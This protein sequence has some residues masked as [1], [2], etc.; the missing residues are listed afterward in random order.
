MSDRFIA[1]ANNIEVAAEIL[2]EDVDV[3]QVKIALRMTVVDCIEA[4]EMTEKNPELRESFDQL[5]ESIANVI[6]ITSRTHPSCIEELDQ[7]EG[8][9]EI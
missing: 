3:K 6:R 5:F 9:Q 2:D 7:D 1:F 4:A 8:V